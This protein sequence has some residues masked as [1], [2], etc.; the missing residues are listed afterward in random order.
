MK[1]EIC[2]RCGKSLEGLAHTTSK[3]NTE[4]ICMECKQEERAMQLYKF[5]SLLEDEQCR[6]G[7]LNYEGVLNDRKYCLL[8][9]KTKISGEIRH[10]KFVGINKLY[11][12]ELCPDELYIIEL[13]HNG[14]SIEELTSWKEVEIPRMLAFA[15]AV[16]QMSRKEKDVEIIHLHDTLKTFLNEVVTDE[17]AVTCA[18][19]EVPKYISKGCF[20]QKYELLLCTENYAYY[21]DEEFLVTDACTGK[22]L[23][24][25]AFAE[26]GYWRSLEAI[27]KGED[28]I[29]YIREGYED[30]V[31][32]QLDEIRKEM[33]ENE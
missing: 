12:D 29:L 24:D 17:V 16:N 7:N 1:K 19:R 9:F 8:D 32:E 11:D 14:K 3:L 5:A 31:N 26:N 2:E 18:G 15:E 6:A 30:A 27:N 13:N 25:N 28:K 4:V 21:G 23:A 20:N 22:L 33:D 10:F